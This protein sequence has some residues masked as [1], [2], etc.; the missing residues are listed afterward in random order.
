MENSLSTKVVVE[1]DPIDEEVID[2]EVINEEV[3]D[4][5]EIKKSVRALVPSFE[6][7]LK[8]GYCHAC[9]EFPMKWSQIVRQYGQEGKIPAASHL[10]SIWHLEAAS[11]AG[12][13]LCRLLFH[14]ISPTDLLYAH[15]VEKM[16]KALDQPTTLL[17]WYEIYDRLQLCY[18]HNSSRSLLPLSTPISVSNIGEQGTF[19]VYF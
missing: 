5:A 8:D 3:I 16:L 13:R 4:H 11:V 10:S 17:I 19:K 7:E 15:K 18:M 12:C 1:H 9:Q 14:Q 2:E 6:E